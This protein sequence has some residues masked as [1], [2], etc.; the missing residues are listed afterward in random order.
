MESTSTCTREAKDSLNKAADLCEE[1][2][3]AEAA[4]RPNMGTG[5]GIVGL[6]AGHHLIG[7]WSHFRVWLCDSAQR[8]GTWAEVVYSSAK[9][10][11]WRVETDLGQFPWH[12]GRSSRW[13]CGEV[14]GTPVLSGASQVGRDWSLF[15]GWQWAGRRFG[16]RGSAWWLLPIH[17][18]RHI[19]E[20]LSK[21]ARRTSVTLAASSSRRK[22][23]SDGLT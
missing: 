12:W 18:V 6:V 1:E 5:I 13:L 23:E 14:Q 17:P 22:E 7:T 21:R 8:F 3:K 16:Q 19:Q 20:R 10:A 15:G 4:A 9:A 11:R 2:R